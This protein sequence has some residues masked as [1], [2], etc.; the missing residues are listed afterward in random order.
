MIEALSD[1][2]K[3]ILLLT[4]PLIIGREREGPEP[5][6]PAQYR[7]LAKALHGAGATP[8]DLL[9]TDAGRWCD[10][11][12]DHCA[13]KVDAERLHALLER[14]IQLAQAVEHW[15]SH[16]L[17]VV[18]RADPDYPRRLRE[19]LRDEAPPILYGCGSRALL[20]TG[21][22]AVVGSRDADAALLEST[23]TI[24]GLAAR[25]RVSLISGGARGIDRAAM[26]G[27]LTNGGRAIGVL[28]ADLQR[29]AVQR[30][31]RA[32]IQDECLVLLSPYDPA[33]SFN[34]GHAMQRNKLIYALADAALVM[35]SDLKKGG[36]WAG[37]DEQL[38]K[39][40]FVPVYV[41]LGTAP[42]PGLAALQAAGA[43]SW[44]EP[45]DADALAELLDGDITHASPVV[46][47]APSPEQMLDSVPDT[48]ATAHPIETRPPA[49]TDAVAAH[50]NIRP[51]AAETLFDTVRE[52]IQR[53]PQP[54]T[55]ADIAAELDVGKAQAK[56]WLERLV[57][58]GVLEKVGRPASY[59]F[60]PGGFRQGDLFG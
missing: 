23:G 47:V 15:S 24:G 44:P 5:L 46:A 33:A 56:V 42:S 6:T 26:N 54:L 30:D 11:L 4:A 13:P 60:P 48:T 16:A 14:G 39:Y 31:H 10:L 8:A 32:F 9:G 38:R 51:A 53:H 25:A 28:A 27:T 36:T 52:L 50:S 29:A 41:H 58:E 7:C 43:R 35:S 59:R 19:R 57:T 17:W 12:A 21:G 45:S 37:A 20:G 2:T 49:S 40:R 34:V 1:N 55:D 18:S 3:A 22:L